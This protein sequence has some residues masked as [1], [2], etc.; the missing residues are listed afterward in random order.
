MFGWDFLGQP[1]GFDIGETGLMAFDAMQPLWSAFL[2]GLANTLRVSLPAL[3]LATAFGLLLALG[4][5]SSS[6][7]V[8][9]L[10]SFTIGSVRHVPL[11]LQLLIWYFL[12]IE[13]L[14]DSTQA[15]QLAPGVWLSKGGLSFPWP[16]CPGDDGGTEQAPAPR[17]RSTSQ[18]QQQTQ[19]GRQAQRRQAHAQGVAQPHRQRTPDRLG[20]FVRQQ[21]GFADVK[22]GGLK[23]EIPGEQGNPAADRRQRTGGA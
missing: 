7:G 12:L 1:A 6:P 10:A 16:T 9:Q 22:A 3:L 19:H 15:I 4:R 17:C 18:G 21:A 13:W 14:P 2:V 20:R 5:R 23:E 11:L 8:K